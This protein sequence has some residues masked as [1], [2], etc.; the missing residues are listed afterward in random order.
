M[1]KVPAIRGRLKITVARSSHRTAMFEAYDEAYGA[2]QRFFKDGDR[3]SCPLIEEY[4][5]PC[6]DK[7][8]SLRES[9][10][11]SHGI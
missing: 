4:E 9:A 10:M 3:D 7:A 1:M 2:L 11:T 6:V 5:A 8:R